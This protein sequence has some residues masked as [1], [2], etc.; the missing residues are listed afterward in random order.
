M[1]QKPKPIPIQYRAISSDMVPTQS[2]PTVDKEETASSSPS[3]ELKKTTESSIK[4]TPSLT[5]TLGPSISNISRDKETSETRS[6][7]SQSDITQETTIKEGTN[8][9][10]ATT[11][12][13]TS[14]SPSFVPQKITDCSPKDASSSTSTVN[15]SI[16]PIARDQETSEIASIRSQSNVTQERTNKEKTNKGAATTEMTTSSSPSVGTE[17]TT[18]CAPMNASSATSTVNPSISSVTWDQ[19]MSEIVVLR[20]QSSASHS[21]TTQEK[22]KKSATAAE[23]TTS[24]SLSVIT[25]KTTDGF[26]KDASSS[27]STLKPSTFHIIRH[28]DTAAIETIL[29]LDS[30]EI[31]HNNYFKVYPGCKFKTRRVRAA[32]S[33]LCNQAAI[34]DTTTS[35]HISLTI[36]HSIRREMVTLLLRHLKFRDVIDEASLNYRVPLPEMEWIR[37]LGIKEFCKW[38]GKEEA[39]GKILPGVVSGWVSERKRAWEKFME[40]DSKG[41]YPV[42][43]RKRTESVKED[44]RESEEDPNKGSLVVGQ[45]S[46]TSLSLLTEPISPPFKRTS[47]SSSHP[48]K[49]VEIEKESIQ[50]P[51]D[52]PT[53][54]DGTHILS[55]FYTNEDSFLKIFKLCRQVKSQK[56]RISTF[57]RQLEITSNDDESLLSF[58]TYLKR[59]IEKG[60]VEY[61]R[62]Q[63]E[64]AEAKR[65]C[66]ELV[67]GDDA[68]R[69]VFDRLNEDILA[70]T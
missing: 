18:N 51:S 54:I 4:N 11:E 47:S 53:E 57:K 26:P 25:E 17:K 23:M 15:P 66:R 58:T 44:S 67:S 39:I 63:K 40:D 16:S 29:F 65:K 12:M 10:T 42:E 64:L 60:D 61:K 22:T 6:I 19:E 28:K 69:I 20:P 59:E 34:F 36:I 1:D 8:K 50:I 33:I 32:R 49:D 38:F 37:E 68:M 35:R 70:V 62:I 2:P 48:Q 14:S 13:T 52:T 43:K 9:N 24:S 56:N 7:R 5:S 55:D 41:E 27:T 21:K 45:R 3:V 46:R 31:T 30:C